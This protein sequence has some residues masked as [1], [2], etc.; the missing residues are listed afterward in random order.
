MPQSTVS[1]DGPQCLDGRDG[2]RDGAAEG[3]D[4]A[5]EVEREDGPRR[6]VLLPGEPG[7]GPV[8]SH[9]CQGRQHNRR[10][11]EHFAC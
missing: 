1:I 5:L 7:R 6:V 3:G 8:G 2:E 11:V 10:S 4:D 9:A